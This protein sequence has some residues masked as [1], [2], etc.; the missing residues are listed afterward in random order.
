[1][2]W[3]PCI[4][5]TLLF[6]PFLREI[7]YASMRAFP[8]RMILTAHKLLFQKQRKLDFYI[9]RSS[10]TERKHIPL[11]YPGTLQTIRNLF[12]DNQTYRWPLC[13]I[14]LG[15]FLQVFSCLGLFFFVTIRY[16]NFLV[17]SRWNFI[18]IHENVFGEIPYFFFLRLFC[19][20]Q[21]KILLLW[22]ICWAARR[23][24]F[25]LHKLFTYGTRFSS[26]IFL[27]VGVLCIS[28]QKAR[29]LT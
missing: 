4:Q 9:L 14:P 13:L 11:G 29:V 6:V 5:R 7:R 12:F 27:P 18:Q 23:G 19:P 22:W 25:F 2:E 20:W 1:M 24:R 8:E 17:N 16:N 28:T 3:S 10:D 15:S 21:G 26:C